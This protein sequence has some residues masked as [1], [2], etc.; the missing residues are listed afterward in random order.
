MPCAA[1]PPVPSGAAA[2]PLLLVT[3]LSGAR[4]HGGRTLPCQT[5]RKPWFGR[6]VGPNAFFFGI[7]LDVA[8]ACGARVP[9]CRLNELQSIPSFMH[10][11]LRRDGR[12]Q[13]S[14]ISG[15]SFLCRLARPRIA[16]NLA[17]TY[18]LRPGG[19]RHRRP[20]WRHET[21]HSGSDRWF[22]LCNG[23][24]APSRPPPLP[25]IDLQHGSR[26]N[27]PLHASS[28]VAPHLLSET[29]WCP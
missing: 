25:W 4:E 26:I 27:P 10:D 23:R 11:I 17:A 6:K 21:R 28:R 19:E 29:S 1:P 7:L 20:A 9:I 2:R 5:G 3:S 18:F 16:E 24:Q 15:K 12:R 8:A 22:L 13:L 14:P